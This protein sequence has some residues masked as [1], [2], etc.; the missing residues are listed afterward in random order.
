MIHHFNRWP[1]HINVLWPFF[2][3]TDCE[4]D[5]EN[6]LLPLRLLLSQYES[7]DA[8][9]NEIGTF[10]ENNICFMKLNEG[11]RDHVKRLYEQVKQLFSTMLYKQSQYV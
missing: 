2:D 11:S 6:I 5:E 7:F 10:I 8:E 9:V 1:P 3:L 4:D